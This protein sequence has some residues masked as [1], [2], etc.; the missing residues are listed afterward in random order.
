MEC[1]FKHLW[2]FYRSAGN[3]H[4]NISDQRCFTK[5]WTNIHF[6][7]SVTW[8]LNQ[9]YILA[10]WGK[11][12]TGKY[13]EKLIFLRKNLPKNKTK[14][15]PNFFSGEDIKIRKFI[16]ILFLSMWCCLT[17]QKCNSLAVL[18]I[19]F[20]GLDFH[21]LKMLLTK[22]RNFHRYFDPSRIFY[23]KSIDFYP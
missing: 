23:S 14:K 10:S 12:E 9:L 17:L 22:T 11:I 2:F 20:F 5:N 15:I 1:I 6:F 19:T 13:I 8:H 3:Y 21:Y 4:A 7:L 16:C 18:Q